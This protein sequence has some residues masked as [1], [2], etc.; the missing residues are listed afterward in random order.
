MHTTNDNI[1]DLD[2]KRLE[3]Q[4]SDALAGLPSEYMEALKGVNISDLVIGALPKIEVT[5]VEHFQSHMPKCPLPL[6]FALRQ[7]VCTMMMALDLE[8][9]TPGFLRNLERARGKLNIIR[10]GALNILSTLG[11]S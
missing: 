3:K 5:M 10:T 8:A 2:K 1:T 9:S 7:S 6:Q 4:L 11:W